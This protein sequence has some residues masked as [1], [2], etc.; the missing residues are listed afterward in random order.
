MTDITSKQQC[1]QLCDNL[2]D[3]VKFCS[4]TDSPDVGMQYEPGQ[5][6]AIFLHNNGEMGVVVTQKERYARLTA[7]VTKVGNDFCYSYD[8]K[9]SVPYYIAA[10]LVGGIVMGI[11]GTVVL[12]KG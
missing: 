10:A 7:A 12:K 8:P 1:V 6:D 2:A 5:C 9:A 4:F 3:D 11:G